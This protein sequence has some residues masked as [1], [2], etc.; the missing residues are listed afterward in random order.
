MVRVC[1]ENGHALII[2]HG[3]PEKRMKDFK[4]Y[5]CSKNTIIRNKKISLS[6]L[7][8]LINLLRTDLQDKPLK[9]ALEN[10]E[11]LKTAVKE[12]K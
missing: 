12:R 2:T 7:A 6:D 11:Y 3:T 4:S 1:K 9:Y 8:Q 10:Q 5:E